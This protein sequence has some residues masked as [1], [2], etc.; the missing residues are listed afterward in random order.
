MFSTNDDEFRRIEV[1]IDGP[2]GEQE[3]DVS[4]DLRITKLTA[5]PTDDRLTDLARTIA[6]AQ[7]DRGMQVDRIRVAV[8]RTDFALETLERRDELI[9][10]VTIDLERSSL[11]R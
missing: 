11:L 1:W 5:Y 4:Q 9:R 2:E 8:W 3:L 7:Q 6:Q 10:E